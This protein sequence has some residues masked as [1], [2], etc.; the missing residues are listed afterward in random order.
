MNDTATSLALDFERQD[1]AAHSFEDPAVPLEL[2]IEEVTKRAVPRLRYPVTDISTGRPLVYSLLHDGVEIPRD[3]TVGKA[4]PGRRR[5]RV[6][7]VSEFTN[8]R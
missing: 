1:G 5:A 8:A 7:V 6:H 4:F 2:S 3:L